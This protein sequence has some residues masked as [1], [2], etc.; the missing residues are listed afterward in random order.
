MFAIGIRYL[1]IQSRIDSTQL[2]H[3]SKRIFDACEILIVFRT[4]IVSQP[5]QNELTNGHRKNH[6]L[7][8]KLHYSAG[9]TRSIGEQ[10]YRVNPSTYRSIQF[11]LFLVPDQ[12]IYFFPRYR[13]L[14]KRPIGL[15]Q[16]TTF[17]VQTGTLLMD[18]DQNVIVMDTTAVPHVHDHI[19]VYVCMCSH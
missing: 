17:P 9:E 13:A 18:D 3:C 4:C 15:L 8:A 6:R 10:A 19:F 11:V 16:M 5:T 12:F 1:S 2:I 7:I 14:M